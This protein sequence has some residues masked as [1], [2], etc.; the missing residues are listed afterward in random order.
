MTISAPTQTSVQPLTA[1]QLGQFR[2]VRPL[3]DAFFG[4]DHID[5]VGRGHVEH[6]VVGPYV[7][8]LPHHLQQLASIALLQRNV[9]AGSHHQVQG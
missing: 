2:G 6:R 5:Q 3:D 7:Q 8:A 1:H 9:I 4:H